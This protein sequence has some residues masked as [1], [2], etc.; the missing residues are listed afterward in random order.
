MS[1]ELFVVNFLEQA[2]RTFIITA[3]Q[4]K[5]HSLTEVVTGIYNIYI[6]IISLIK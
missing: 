4:L 6:Y 1:V 3:H 5:A 2:I